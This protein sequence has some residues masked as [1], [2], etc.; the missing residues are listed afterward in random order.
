MLVARVLAAAGLVSSMTLVLAPAMATEPALI[1]HG[2][3]AA[4]IRRVQ[5][6]PPVAVPKREAPTPM[7]AADSIEAALESRLD[8]RALELAN[9]RSQVATLQRALEVFL[10]SME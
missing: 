8:Q 9:L 3:T 4:V 5:P 10:V 2:E 6:T 1:E 7:P